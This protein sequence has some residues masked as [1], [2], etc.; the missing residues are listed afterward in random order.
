MRKR[1]N[2]E[3]GFSL[4]ELLIVVAILGILAAVVLPNFTG[5]LGN[6]Q[7]RSGEAELTIVQTAVDAKMAAENLATITAVTVATGDMTSAGFDLSPQYMRSDATKGTY[8][9]DATGEVTQVTTGY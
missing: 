1:L 6:A 7:S 5:L 9:M 2:T 4:T 3:Q 8:T